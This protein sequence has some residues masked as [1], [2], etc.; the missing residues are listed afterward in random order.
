M[1]CHLNLM[2][3]YKVVCVFLGASGGIGAATAVKYAKERAKL[4]LSGRNETN[5]KKTVKLCEEQGAKTANVS[6][7]SRDNGKVKCRGLTAA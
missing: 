1:F 5:L 4:V 2:L 3:Q 7:K 6:S